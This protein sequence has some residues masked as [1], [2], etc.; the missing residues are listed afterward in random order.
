[1]RC[2]QITGSDDRMDCREMFY[3]PLNPLP[4]KC[5]T[6][7]FP[8][9]DHVPQPYFLVKSRTLT[10]NELAL[11]ENGSFFVR[12]RVRRVLEVLAPGQCSYFPTCYKGTSQETPWLL[13]VPSHQVVTGKVKASIPRC[14]ACGEPRSAHPGT[15]WSEH[16]FIYGDWDYDVLKSATWAS[17]ERGWDQWVSRDLFLSVRLFQL[18]R[19]I[20][21]KGFYELG[22][23][24]PTPPDKEESEWIK[25]KLHV[26]QANGIS[27]H[28]EGTLSS[29][30]AKWL[31]NYI[32]SHARKAK[33]AWDIKTVERRLKARLPKSYVDFV[34]AVG[35]VSF[36][37]VDEQQG[38]TASILAPGK[39]R[40][41]EHA[42]DGEDEESRAVN[43]LMFAT[44]GHGDYFCFDVQ[45]GKK[46]LPVLL[47]KHE[48]NCFEP[49][50]ENFAACIKRFAGGGADGKS[51]VAKK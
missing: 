36:E 11:A 4:R 19:K 38:F 29:E 16:L 28:A 21:A 3:D 1:M 5:A 15:Q 45:K 46:E 14:K 44:T 6:C 2:V 26:M 30:D 22:G 37:N 17:S 47:F 41:Q 10:P 40:L 18:L 12:Q 24:E 49:Y 8:D 13:A 31:R 23:E 43:A 25:E 32:K 7:G 42:D 51:A 50:A 35:P 9:L 20:Q 34:S 33:A 48:Y 27:C 39:L